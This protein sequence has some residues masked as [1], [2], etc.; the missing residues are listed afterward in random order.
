MVCLQSIAL[1]GEQSIKST[2]QEGNN[3]VTSDEK[4]TQYD[5]NTLYAAM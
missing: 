4:T 5:K 1:M 3:K 2:F